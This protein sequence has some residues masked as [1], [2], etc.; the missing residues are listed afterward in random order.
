[1]PEQQ[2]ERRR[3]QVRNG[4]FAGGESQLQTRLC[5]P[6]FPASWENTGKFIDSGF[7]CPNLH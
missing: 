1:M 6:K 2:R 4:L 5:F 7:R 3:R